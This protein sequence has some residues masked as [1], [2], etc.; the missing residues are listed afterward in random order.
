M[1]TRT[2]MANMINLSKSGIKHRLTCDDERIRRWETG[3]V[4]WPREPYRLAIEEVTHRDVEDLG[5]VPTKRTR[6]K[7]VSA[8]PLRTKEIANLA[9]GCLHL[10]N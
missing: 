1:L 10:A 6:S 8:Q 9:K 3:Q 5:F 7:D 4:R 2:E